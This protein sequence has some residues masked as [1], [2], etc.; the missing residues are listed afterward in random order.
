MTKEIKVGIFTGLGVLAFLIS[1]VLLGGDKFIFKSTYHLKVH[2]P[3]VQGLARGSIVSLEGV[4]VGN[5]HRL[6]F[7]PQTKQIEVVLDIDSEFKNRITEGSRA[8]VKT[9]GELGDKYIYIEGGPLTGKVLAENTVV[10]S[11]PGGD[12]ID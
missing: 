4:P 11:A 12:L 8:S 1:I 5:V 10:E 6:D 3:D 2:L 7:L 9:Q